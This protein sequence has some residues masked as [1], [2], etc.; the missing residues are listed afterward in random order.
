MFIKYDELELFEFF[1]NEPGIIGEYEGGE[2]IYSYKYNNFNII[3]SI[4]TYEMNIRTSISYNDNIIYSQ[5]HSGILEIK[6][7]DSNTLKVITDRQNL[8]VIMK[9]PQIGII[10]EED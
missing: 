5:K 7:V 6:K 1:E 2:L 4:S 10:V 8:I 9:E 3:V